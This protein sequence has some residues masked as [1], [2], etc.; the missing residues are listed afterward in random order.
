[1]KKPFAAIEQALGKRRAKPA[2][3]E[4][5]HAPAYPPEAET[6]EERDGFEALVA[7]IAEATEAGLI[8]ESF[9]LQAASQD[10]AFVDLLLELPPEAAVRVYTAEQRADQAEKAARERVT[11]EVRSRGALPKPTR[12][13]G[14]AS[15]SADYRSM[16]SEEFRKLER[17]FRL[18]SM[19]G[20]RPR[21]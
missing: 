11:S 18:A 17:A 16:S 2:A 10:P 7:S 20:E 21:L 5:E 13:G 19:N 14:A 3:A 9:D 4:P 12:A 6:P 15:P 1:M 8:P